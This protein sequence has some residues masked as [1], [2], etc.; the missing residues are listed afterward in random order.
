[1]GEKERKKTSPL[2]PSPPAVVEQCFETEYNAHL[3]IY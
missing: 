2:F 3:D 1:M